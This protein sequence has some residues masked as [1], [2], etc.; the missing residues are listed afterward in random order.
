MG[1]KSASES[2]ALCSCALP[3]AI[4]LLVCAASHS[5]EPHDLELVP[6][7]QMRCY[8]AGAV[9]LTLD[10]GS[11]ATFELESAV[12]VVVDDVVSMLPGF[13]VFVAGDVVDGKLANLRAVDA[14]AE[15]EDVLQ[16]RMWQEPGK[17]DTFLLVTNHFHDF[18][19]YDAAML[20]PQADNFRRTSSCAVLGDGR[21]GY[22]HWPHTIL[23]L[24][25]VDFTFL[26]PDVEEVACE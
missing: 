16:I 20:L 17:P 15:L 22:E 2:I 11:E 9:P 1:P 26:S 21:G 24:V 13:T 7:E 8:P 5:Q 14:P 19:K 18:V 4:S 3:A 10:D 25:L 12:S 6:C 23:Q